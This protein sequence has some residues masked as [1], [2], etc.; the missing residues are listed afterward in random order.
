MYRQVSNF[1]RL[2]MRE[3]MSAA[4]PVLWDNLVVSRSEGSLVEFMSKVVA[5][6]K[7]KRRDDPVIR[8]KFFDVRNYVHTLAYVARQPSTAMVTWENVLYKGRMTHGYKARIAIYLLCVAMRERGLS[9]L[10]HDKKHMRSSWRDDAL[11]V[12]LHEVLEVDARHAL[13]A[14]ESTRALP[15]LADAAVLVDEIM[16]PA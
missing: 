15:C 10:S 4:A 14:P 12:V 16:L 3:G 8:K 5:A 2:R 11:M 1:L 6:D 7:F 9:P 13:Y